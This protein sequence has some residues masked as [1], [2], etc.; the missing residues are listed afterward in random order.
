M[1]KQIKVVIP[2]RYASTRL[3]GKP[4]LE[5]NNKPIYWY[6]VQQVLDAGVEI[7]DIVV[8]TDDER[9]V[10]SAKSLGVPVQLTAYNH[11]SGTDR[12]NEVASLKEWADDVIIINVQGDEPLIPCELISQLVDFT[13]NNP[14]FSITTA[15]SAISAKVDYFNPNIVKALMGENNRALYFTRSPSPFNR[16]DPES[17]LYSFYHIGIYA[18][19]VDALREFCLYPESK[20]EVCEKLEQLR[21]LS[22]GMAIGAIVMDKMPHHGIDTPQDY[23]RLKLLMEA[24]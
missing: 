4:L 11:V 5:V 23:E 17:Y 3:P 21:A 22:N 9:I 2:A 24:L 7:T 18:Y 16:D 6:V 19:R 8:A 14:H 13:I 20:L 15:V 12:I 10:Q 1:N